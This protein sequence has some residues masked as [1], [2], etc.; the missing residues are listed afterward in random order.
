MSWVTL[1][2]E[3]IRWVWSSDGEGRVTWHSHPGSQ[4]RAETPG[5]GPGITRGSRN[6][7]SETTTPISRIVWEHCWLKAQAHGVVRGTGYRDPRTSQ[8]KLACGSEKSALC[9]YRGPHLLETQTM[10]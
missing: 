2:F 4:L 5:L 8:Q 1:E 9:Y 10:S 3:T 6:G 7:A